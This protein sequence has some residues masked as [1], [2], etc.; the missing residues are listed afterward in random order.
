MRLFIRSI[1]NEL[2]NNHYVNSYY[3]TSSWFDYHAAVSYNK[4]SSLIID[5]KGTSGTLALAE[6]ISSGFVDRVE[7][8]YN[9]F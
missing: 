6:V 5:K 4:T 7:Y 2:K 8:A 9:P 3:F 1:K